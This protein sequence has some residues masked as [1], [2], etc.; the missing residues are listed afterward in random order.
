VD[1]VVFHI[2]KLAVRWYG[3]SY[4][5]SFLGGALILGDLA[6]R[7]RWPV[8]PDRVL[9]VLF[10]GILG[11]FLGG[12]IGWVLFYGMH[13][14]DWAWSKAWTVWEGGM[15]FHGGL[16]GVIVAYWIYAART[17]VP[18]GA[19]FD[20]LA[21][22][23]TPGLFLVRIANY[24]NAELYGT[25]WNGPW[26]VRFPDYYAADVGGPEHWEERGARWLPDL[27]H[28]SQLYEA[29]VEGVL[30]FFLLRWLML[31]LGVGGGRIAGLFLLLYGGSRFFLEYVRQPDAGL[32]YPF[33]GM[34]TRGQQL[35]LGMMVA[36]VVV[37]LVCARKPDSG[38]PEPV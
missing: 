26:A 1:P 5:L 22:A 33:L 21:L 11:V 12:R 25:V 6:K 27:R 37:L 31:R 38:I 4:V 2:G 7:G 24:V 23:T 9:D 3:I 20:G 28:P 18:R 35:C 36:G 19:L 8:A 14:A 13:Q 17:H 10:W 29:L 30:L 34:F 16:L 32:D 15:S